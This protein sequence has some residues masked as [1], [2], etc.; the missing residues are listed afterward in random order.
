MRLRFFRLHLFTQRGLNAWAICD[1]AEA[2]TGG[3]TKIANRL[4][5]AVITTLLERCFD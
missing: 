3:A 5:Q 1:H 4:K 2:Y